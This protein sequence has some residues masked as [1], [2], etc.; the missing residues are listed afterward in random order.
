MVRRRSLDDEEDDDDH[1]ATEASLDEDDS[2]DEADFDPAQC[3]FCNHMNS[4]FDDNL[5]HMLKMHG[6]FITDKDRLVVDVETLIAYFHL[7]IFGYFQCL[8]CST[9]RSSTEAVQQHMMRKAHC[10]FDISSEDFGFH[11]FYH[12]DSSH[13]T[14]EEE[15]AE[16]P[17]K[18]STFSLVQLD[19]DAS[20]VLPSGKVLSHRSSRQHRPRQHNNHP[21]VGPSS[22][23]PDHISS[24][25][26]PTTPDRTPSHSPPGALRKVEKRNAALKTQ[27]QHLRGNDL[28]SLMHMPTS[29]QRA[30]LATQ[31]KQMDKAR[32]AER[33][34]QSRVE[35]RG[36]KTLMKHF[37]CDVP[38]RKNG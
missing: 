22:P 21:N 37:V 33:M 38:G 11:E 2:Q 1:G 9:I 16:I 3:V 13:E 31:K 14:D 27:L 12:F 8:Y 19:D 25:F 32:K 5:I 18:R 28:R 29:Q 17:S 15:D 35:G 6:L 7:I 23:Q 20:C 26:S 10:K 36:N 24:T 34:M 30:L 4:S